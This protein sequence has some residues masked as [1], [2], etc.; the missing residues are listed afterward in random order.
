MPC[1]LHTPAPAPGPGRPL[2][3]PH[4]TAT[5]PAQQAV[6]DLLADVDTPPLVHAERL[7][8]ARI[9]LAEDPLLMSDLDRYELRFLE[10]QAAR[11]DSLAELA[12]AVATPRLVY[13]QRSLRLLE[14]SPEEAVA[15]PYD[16]AELRASFL[17]EG[18]AEEAER[19][20]RLIRERLRCEGLK[21]ALEDG[22]METEARERYAGVATEEEELD[23]E[24]RGQLLGELATLMGQ[25]HECTGRRIY[26]RL[27]K[28]LTHARHD[29]E[30]AVRLE[31]VLTR[32]GVVCLEW[33][34]LLLLLVVLV[35]LTVEYTTNLS[36]DWYHIL[37]IADGS[38][39]CFFITE[40]LFKLSLAPA[41]ASWFLR[42]AITDL[43]P[44]IP[45]ALGL[46]APL[47]AHGEDA[48]ALRAARVFRIVNIARYVQFLRPVLGIFRLFLFLVRGMD[49]LVQRFSPLLNRNFVFFEEGTHRG[50]EW[51][52]DDPRLLC[53]AAIRR[54]HVL[55]DDQPVTASHAALVQRAADLAQRLDSRPLAR[56]QFQAAAQEAR[57][58]PVEEAIERLYRLRPEE[59]QKTMPRTDLL[60][61][62]RVSRVLNAPVIRSLPFIRW[63]RSEQPG[64]SPELRVV[65]LGRRI[66]D[67]LERWRN[68][69]LFFADLH[70][71]VT[72]PQVLDR[73]ATAMVKASKR[74]A[75]RLLLFGALFWIVQALFPE[76]SGLNK[77][78]EKFVATPLVVLGTVCFVILFT[79]R[80]LKRLAGEAAESLKRTS[81][82]HF[83]NL[84]ELVKARTKD[85]DLIYLA[86]RLFRFEMDSWEA[87]LALGRQVE[88]SSS[89]RITLDAEGE[90]REPPHAVREDLSRVAYLYLHFLDGAILHESDIKTT[91]Q[92]LANLSLENI[93]RHHLRFSRK[94]LKRVRSLSLASGSMFSGPYLWFRFITESVSL[95]SAKRIT[96]YNRH[97]LTLDQRQVASAEEVE[98]MEQWMA[99]RR[100][101]LEGRIIEKLD[102]PDAGAIYRT[103]EF[104]SMDFLSNNLHRDAEIARIFGSEVLELLQADRRCMIRE[105]FGTRPL[106]QMPRSK[107]SINFYRSYLNLLSR[108]R[109]LLAPLFFLGV[110]WWSLRS[111]VQKTLAVVREILRPQEVGEQRESGRA[112][113]RVALRKI[114]R[115]KAPGLLEAMH[116]RACFDPAYCGAPPS[117]SFGQQMEEEPEVE[118]DM[119]FLQLR[120][121][122]RVEIRE[123]AATNRQRVERLHDLVRDVLLFDEKHD[124]MQRRLGER[125]V[126]IAYMTD[127]NGMRSL[128]RAERWLERELPRLEARDFY[129]PGSAW[130]SL[131]CWVQR[132][133]KRHPVRRLIVERLGERR[134]SRRGRRNL[135]RAWLWDE[136]ETRAI[137]AAWLEL[138]VGESPLQRASQL[139][140]DFYRASGEVSRELIALRAVQTLSVLDVRNYRDLIFQLGGYAA[141][142]EDPELV[143]P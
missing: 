64:D 127:R 75:V 57:D 141:E 68:R 128:L 85:E 66:A 14:G 33:M 82:A 140:R 113:F 26:R 25:L 142:G 120:E 41:K 56:R 22:R 78:L 74:P 121:R 98:E 80:Y 52:P 43:L 132:G 9:G 110:I 114:H 32:R 116:M 105:I 38:I 134:I 123:I 61:L 13:L 102:P 47:P 60:A 69:M 70:G 90:Y 125:A 112:P 106:H 117:W 39:C 55:L 138:P 72:G 111:V 31:S 20:T 24:H 143:L 87:A 89:G 18:R 135:R 63:F 3:P 99:A 45:A 53:F 104:N 91:E 44:A 81:E 19:C 133:F 11:R 139:A 107:R 130:R 103:T 40:F 124:E 122:E 118:R 54:E 16:A 27:Q 50:D 58:V 29:R 109:V 35:L 83:I 88:E 17:A 97:C 2:P 131:C 1:V 115:M 42:N 6:K 5:T 79:G 15:T 77:F 49:A 34:S 84:L 65:S 51:D 36:R 108:G 137:V 23:L 59:V 101:H 21:P 62:D 71:I 96:E 76:D 48:A 46:F 126:T 28:R 92:L 67:Q 100:A 12:E 4:L 119:D 10:R 136:G 93:R 129:L 86:K 8:A 73:V 95:E 94:D 37:L 7:A 30:L